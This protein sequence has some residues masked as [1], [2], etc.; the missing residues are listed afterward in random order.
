MFENCEICQKVLSWW[1]FVAA[2]IVSVLNGLLNS[3]GKTTGFTKFIN[4]VIDILSF[5]TRKDSPGTV[6]LP[7]TK[8]KE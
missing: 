1:P 2:A 7:F 8:S 5:T 4:V 6:K 3:Y